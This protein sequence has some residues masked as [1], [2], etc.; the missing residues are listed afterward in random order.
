MQRILKNLNQKKQKTSKANIALFQKALSYETKRVQTQYNFVFNKY[1]LD[2]KDPE[3]AI[4][5]AKISD[6]SKNNYLAAYKFYLRA[7]GF[8]DVEV[9]LIKIQGVKK[10]LPS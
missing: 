9:K 1:I 2:V 7:I 5:D 3:K 10:A 8:K 4:L 6:V